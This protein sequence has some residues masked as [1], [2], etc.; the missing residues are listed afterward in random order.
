VG[1]FSISQKAASDLENLYEYGLLEF[2]IEVAD[3]YFDGLVSKIELLA[4]SPLIG[5]AVDDIR[6]G[7]RLG[8]FKYHSIYYKIENSESILII[9]VLRGHDLT[10][11][12]E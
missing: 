2:G 8:V 9:R 7:Y 3:E 6:A 5:K 12:F 11:S 10:A 4:K 1:K